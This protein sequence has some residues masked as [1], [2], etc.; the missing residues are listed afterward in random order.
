[1]SHSVPVTLITDQLVKLGGKWINVHNIGSI[2][3][4][5]EDGKITAY[6]NDKTK[7]WVKVKQKEKDEPETR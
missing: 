3:I 2:T 4:D 7:K 5:P 6:Y 1:M